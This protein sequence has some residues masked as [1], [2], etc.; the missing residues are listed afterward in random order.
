MIGGRGAAAFAFVVAVAAVPPTAVTAANVLA[1]SIL[2]PVE[3]ATPAESAASAN[4]PE[5]SGHYDQ[6]ISAATPHPAMASTCVTFGPRWGQAGRYFS[7]M[8]MSGYG[9]FYVKAR[10]YDDDWHWRS[11]AYGHPAPAPWGISE[12][13]CPF[14]T[15]PWTR[16]VVIL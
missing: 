15:H 14:G 1:A 7:A 2:P 3:A 11:T 12:G 9:F 10:C 8:C 13:Y 5:S 16:W 6:P 4:E